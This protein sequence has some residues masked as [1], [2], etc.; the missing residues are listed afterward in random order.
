MLDPD[1][2]Y[3]V[4]HGMV[5]CLELVLVGLYIPPSATIR[6]LHKITTLIATYST[7]NVIFMGDF[8]MP[9]N[10]EMECFTS[11]GGSS[12]DLSVWAKAYGFTNVW[13]WKHPL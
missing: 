13:R 2:R 1:G 11:T 12:S 4:I 9:P 5:E 6:L 10:P 7:D 3:V 8:N